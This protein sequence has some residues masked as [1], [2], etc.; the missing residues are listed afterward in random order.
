MIYNRKLG[1]KALEQAGLAKF[2]RDDDGNIKNLVITIKGIKT[3]SS[4]KTG[5]GGV[6]VHNPGQRMGKENNQK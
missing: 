3:Y 1:L 5:V 4:V 2:S 6:K